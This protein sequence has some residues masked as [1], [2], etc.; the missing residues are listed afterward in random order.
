MSA[1]WE[2]CQ[3]VSELQRHCANLQ[4]CIDAQNEVLAR[5]ATDAA[6]SRKTI[7]RVRALA[8]LWPEQALKYPGEAGELY[9]G[10]VPL[11][12][13]VT[14]TV[15]RC[16]VELL[17]TLNCTCDPDDPTTPTHRHEPADEEDKSPD[18]RIQ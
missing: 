6:E 3:E 14:I 7:R 10:L 9:D 13:T 12:P 2:N 4:A 11:G 1:F 16:A 18:D 5:L 15:E 8:K 17:S